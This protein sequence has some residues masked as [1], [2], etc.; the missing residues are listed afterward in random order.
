[1]G[2]IWRGSLDDCLQ[3]DLLHFTLSTMKLALTGTAQLLIS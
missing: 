2:N 1:M 3:G